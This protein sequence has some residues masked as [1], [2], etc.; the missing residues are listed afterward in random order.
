MCLLSKQ[1][2]RLLH[3]A[4]EGQLFGSGCDD[5]GSRKSRLLGTPE[6][7]A[8]G[9]DWFGHGHSVPTLF[10][11]M[12]KLE[13]SVQGESAVLKTDPLKQV[14]ISQGGN[15]ASFREKGGCTNQ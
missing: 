8:L 9:A 14:R 2:L 12:E 13:V 6:T 11:R 7:E 3:F 10:K 15:R 5:P 1:S 4:Q